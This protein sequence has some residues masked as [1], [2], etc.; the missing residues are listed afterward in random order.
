MPKRVS[1]NARFLSRMIQQI[2]EAGCSDCP[3]YKQCR[4]SV[5]YPVDDCIVK[6]RDAL[7]I[8]EVKD[9]D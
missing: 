1:V 6:L 4:V 7:K 2:A 8:E 5:A 3:L 9:G